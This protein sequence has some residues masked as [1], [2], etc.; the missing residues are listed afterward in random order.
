M[1]AQS[2][3]CAQRTP[4]HRIQAEL[5]CATVCINHHAHHGAHAPH[6]HPCPPLPRTARMQTNCARLFFVGRRAL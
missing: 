4:P 6:A 1:S 2:A 5:S 3:R